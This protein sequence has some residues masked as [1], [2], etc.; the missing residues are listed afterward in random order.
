MA[1]F[2]SLK[3]VNKSSGFRAFAGLVQVLSDHAPS[4]LLSINKTIN[5]RSGCHVGCVMG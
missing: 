5:L 4:L 3:G 2:S 1:V